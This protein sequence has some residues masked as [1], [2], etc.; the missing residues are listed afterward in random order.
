VLTTKNNDIQVDDYMGINDEEKDS[1]ELQKP[2]KTKR[3]RKL[4]KG[5]DAVFLEALETN[6]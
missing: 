1:M 4:K 5:K 2:T 6:L 3:K